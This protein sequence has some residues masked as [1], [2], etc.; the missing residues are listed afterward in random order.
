MSA[1]SIRLRTPATRVRALIEAPAA[2]YIVL[3]GLMIAALALLLHLG[4]GTNF[5]LDDWDFLLNRRGYSPD[6]FLARHSEHLVVLQVVIYKLLFETAGI[7]S[8]LPYRLALLAFH[9]AGAGLLFAYA[10]PRIG[11]WAALL[12]TALLLFLGSGWENTLSAFQIG[13]VGSGVFGLAALIALDHKRD[14]WAMVLL[15]LSICSSGLGIPVAAGIGV[16][17]ALS[18]WRS[19]W[20]VAIPV[21]LWFLWYLGYGESSQVTLDSLLHTPQWALDAAAGAVA[22]LGGLSLEWGRVGL[23]ALTVGLAFGLKRGGARMPTILGLLTIL[24][25]FWTFTGTGRSLNAPA[26]QSRYVYVGAFW[27]LVLGAELATGLRLSRAQSIAATLV[28]LFLIVGNMV[29]LRAGVTALRHSAATIFPDLTALSIARDSVSPSARPFNIETGS[30]LQM[31]DEAESPAPSEDE[32]AAGPTAGR[33]RADTALLSFERAALVAAK[34][35]S[36]QHTRTLAAGS[37]ELPLPAAGLLIRAGSD[38]V[39]VSARRFSTDGA[40]V[41]VISPGTTRRFKLPKD[42]S[43]RPWFVRLT[44]TSATEACGLRR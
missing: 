16:R 31:V 37:T 44:S 5:V 23:L 14:G 3:A 8:Y 35:A 18:R 38:P 28:V 27:I 24:V 39:S 29:P 6:V 42:R 30:Y 13:F 11:P 7:G 43:Q 26:D 41:G 36:C 19:L 4:Q 40:S 10:R 33:E 32:L 22:G 9:L 34:P 17:L 15:L 12:P 2:P 25:G 1:V 20:I 21:A